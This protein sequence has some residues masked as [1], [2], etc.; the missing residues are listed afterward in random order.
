MPGEIRDPDSDALRR[1]T[2]G[3]PTETPADPRDAVARLRADRLR[4]Q[5]ANADRLASIGQ[6]AASVAHEIANPVAFLLAGNARTV[7]LCRNI[8]L[9]VLALEELASSGGEISP[10]A[11]A[12]VLS[13]R[14]V[15]EAASELE[16]I[17]IDSA[18]AIRRVGSIA[19]DLRG[20]A[21][22]QE[23]PSEQVVLDDV[24]RV[25]CRML[26][27]RISG[28][29]VLVQELAAVPAIRGSRTK[30]IQVV[31]N[32]LIN[33]AHAVEDAP[34]ANHEVRV[35]TS[36]SDAHVVLV[37][38]DSGAGIPPDVA[39]RVFE[40]LFTTKQRDRGTG[41]GL[42][43]VDQIVRAHAGSISFSSHVGHGT[44]FEVRFP[45]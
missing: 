44:R 27:P 40:P 25:A 39:P 29:A 3:E 10:A 18:D 12:A 33:A 32:L 38:E 11:L 35:T 19:S 16:A 42:W 14:R 8:M 2:S 26:R 31:T 34:P 9:G 22:V 4:E 21:G 6:L 20:F 17:A 13:E 5:L 28:S 41:L 37:V 45:L 23:D 24:A 1:I 30:L 36:Q 7:E 15:N 43:V